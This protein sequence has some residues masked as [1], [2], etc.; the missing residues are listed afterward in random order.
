MARKKRRARQPE[1]KAREPELSVAMVEQRLLTTSFPRMQMVLILALAAL[2]TFFCSASLVALDVRRMGVRYALAVVGGYAF[3]LSLVRVWIAYQTRNWRFGRTPRE[4]RAELPS[5][6]LND[7][8]D[9]SA[10]A[11]FGSSVGDGFS[12]GGGAFGGAGASGDFGSGGRQREWQ[13][14]RW[15]RERDRRR[16]QCRRRPSDRDCRHR[17]AWRADRRWASWFIRRP[18]CSQ[19]YC[20][21]W[22]SQVL[23]TSETSVTSAATGRGVLRRTYKPMLVLAVFARYSASPCKAWHPRKIRSA[24]CSRAHASKTSHGAH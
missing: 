5:I 12:G 20:W 23:C 21:M 3:F 11:D 7:L 4:Q 13:Q 24:P 2:T 18:R 9:L 22:R 19:R 14:R 6:A 10:L 17:R 15:R 1:S 16:R 8:T